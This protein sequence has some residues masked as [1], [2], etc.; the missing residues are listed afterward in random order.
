VREYYVTPGEKL[1]ITVD[2]T[3]P[4]RTRITA[5]SIGISDGLLGPPTGQVLA[6]TTRLPSHPGTKRFVLHWTAP[7]GLGPDNIRLLAAYWAYSGSGSGTVDQAIAEFVAPPGPAFSA[8][9]AGRLRA[10]ALQEA[11]SCDDQGPRG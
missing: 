8:A 5:L 7:A 1:T 11:R 3:A 6:S 2:V 9:A 10:L 4:G